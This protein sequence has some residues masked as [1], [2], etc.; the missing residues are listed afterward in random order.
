MK[1]IPA[2][3]KLFTDLYNGDPWLG[4]N[5]VD[6]LKNIQ[7]KNANRKVGNHNSIWEILNHL[8]SWRE[9]VLERVQGKTMQSPDHNYFIPVTDESEEAWKATLKKLEESQTK[10]LAFLD[11]FNENDLEKT[12]APNGMN[13]YEHIHGILQHDCYHLGQ[14]NLLVKLVS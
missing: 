6:S 5:L 10:W 13:Y 1:E 4:L 3:S 7:S 8:I 2:I 12:Y 14:I 9:N 11:K